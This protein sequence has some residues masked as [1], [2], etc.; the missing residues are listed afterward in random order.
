MPLPDSHLGLA[1]IFHMEA[2]QG[3]HLSM[4]FSEPQEDWLARGVLLSFL[5]QDHGAGMCDCLEHLGYEA[6]LNKIK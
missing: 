6:Q 3:H 1:I 5:R 2:D 4:G